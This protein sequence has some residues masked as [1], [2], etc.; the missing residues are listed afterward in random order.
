MSLL[1]AATIRNI[2][3]VPICE[4]WQAIW[5]RSSCLYR[6]KV[7]MKNQW[8]NTKHKSCAGVIFGLFKKLSPKMQLDS[9]QINWAKVFS[10][11]LPN[12]PQ[13]PAP[14]TR[15]SSGQGEAVF[16]GICCVH[17]V[18][19]TDSISQ[20]S[21]VVPCSKPLLVMSL[22]SQSFLLQLWMGFYLNNLFIPPCMLCTYCAETVVW[23]GIEY[24][25]RQGK[26]YTTRRLV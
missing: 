17:A 24:K 18:D 5:Y 2:A 11:S 10:A 13:C 23:S 4:L 21:Y 1:N 15:L 22:I 3:L 9:I 14:K 25:K 7:I 20:S 19:F 8:M 12:V 6:S 16:A 26:I